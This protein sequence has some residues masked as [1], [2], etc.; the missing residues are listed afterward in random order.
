M[1]VCGLVIIRS[2]L[3][4]LLIIVSKPE[5]VVA[6]TTQQKKIMLASTIGPIDA[7]IVGALEEAFTKKS[8]IVVEHTGAGTGK[9]IQLAE[10]GLAL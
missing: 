2:C 10:T 9:A 8:G 5:G 4:A 1:Q 3:I 7:G 6:E